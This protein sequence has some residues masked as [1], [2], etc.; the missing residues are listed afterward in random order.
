MLAFSLAGVPQFSEAQS[1]KSAVQTALTSNPRMRAQD[2][3]VRAAAYELLEMR[4]AYAPVVSVFA[5]VGPERIDDPAGLSVR[6]NDRTKTAREMGLIAEL[7][8]FDGYRRANQVYARAARLDR[9]MFE[10]LDA[11]ETMALTVVQAY[12]DVARHQQLL[13]VAQNNLARHLEISRQVTEQVSGGRLP[14]SDQL[15]VESRV[16]NAQITIAELGRELATARAKYRE[17]VGAAP[18]ALSLPASPRIPPSLPAL[19]QSSIA[20]NYRIKQAQANVDTRKFERGINEADY[21]PQ[22]MLRAGGSAGADLDGSSG[23]EDRVFV[24][25]QLDWT[26]FQGGRDERRKALIERQSE[27]LY[28]RMS[29]IREV[30]NLAETAWATYGGN[31]NISAISARR[32]ATNRELV[33]QYLQEFQLA[34]R[35][36]IDVLIAETELFASRYEQ[37]NSNAGLAF[38]GYRMLATQSKLAEHFGVDNTGEVLMLTIQASESEKPFSVIDK[39]LPVVKR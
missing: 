33:D 17:L 8:L 31:Q 18:G 24:G 15:Q 36:L 1:L 22:V 35:S 4:G 25:V 37:V 32:V 13:A 27:A 28:R 3:S 6:D 29:A 30:E 23:Q 14:L 7:P 34:T 39:A 19:V 10:Y 2:A 21:L 12:I 5:T 38:S 9:T 20:N 16:E 11:S 26:I